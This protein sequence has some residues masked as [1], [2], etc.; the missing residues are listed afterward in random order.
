MLLAPFMTK[1]KVTV[2]IQDFCNILGG[3]LV[4]YS[5]LSASAVLQLSAEVQTGSLVAVYHYSPA[6]A[7]PSADTAVKEAEGGLEKQEAVAA[8]SFYAICWKGHTRTLNVMCGKI[9]M[10]D[11]DPIPSIN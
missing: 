3:G 6:D 4:S 7:L 11:P 9:G 8:H 5:T 2:S 10:L 1:R